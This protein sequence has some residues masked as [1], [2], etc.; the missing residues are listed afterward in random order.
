M[1]D[2][3]G[4]YRITERKSSGFGMVGSTDIRNETEIVY[5][6]KSYYDNTS[7]EDIYTTCLDKY[8]H[9]QLARAIVNLIINSIFNEPPDFQ[10]DEEVVK[11][12][13]EIIEDSN[14]NWISWGADLEVH[15]DVFLRAFIGNE[16]KIV[17]IPARSIIVDYAETNILDIKQYVQIFSGSLNILKPGEPL[18]SFAK[19]IPTKEMIHIKI[20]NTSNMVYGSSTLRPVLWWLDVLDN[21]WDRNALRAI[22]YYGAPIVVVTGVPVE[23]QGALKAS[24]EGAGQRPGRNWVLPQDVK[25]EV[26]DFT[27]NYP[28]QDFIDRVY[29]YVLSACNIPQHLV[30]ESDSSRGVA[31]FSGDSFDWM[32]KSRRRVWELGLHNILKYILIEEGIWKDDSE[33]KLN[34]QPVFQRDL[35]DKVQE[36]KMALESGLYSKKTAREVLGVDHSEEVERMKTQKEE[37][38]D[39]LINAQIQKLSN[40]AVKG[41]ASGDK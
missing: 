37:E 6:A 11:R 29:Q 2:L 26:P 16:S 35:K 20:N 36:V 7:R 5:P 12:V 13:N 32:I 8:N 31:M 4:K 22:Q 41:N 14:I 27:K 17:S 28:I 38:P 19:A 10:G 39:E 9:D 21:L 30:Y 40:L 24:L 18:P 33:L 1:N 25:V 15:G 23:H 34:W 3:T